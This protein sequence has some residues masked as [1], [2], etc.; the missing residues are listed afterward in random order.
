[1]DQINK[2]L[3]VIL[4]DDMVFL[5]IRTE[6]EPTVWWWEIPESD[7]TWYWKDKK[8]GVTESYSLE[9]ATELANDESISDW[10]CSTGDF[11]TVEEAVAEITRTAAG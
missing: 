8:V 3:K 11:D 5:I 4:K 9:R 7:W 1:M 2:V 6:D 10:G